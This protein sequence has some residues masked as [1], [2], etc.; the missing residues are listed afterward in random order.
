MLQLYS[1]KKQLKDIK[2]ISTIL[3]LRRKYPNRELLYLIELPICKS[4][5]CKVKFTGHWLRY[6]TKPNV[7]T[8]FTESSQ[9]IKFAFIFFAANL[10]WSLLFSNSDHR[11][12]LSPVYQ[13][14]HLITQHK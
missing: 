6:S 13:L 5:T 14:L 10:T 9:A 8:P 1:E 11:K 4:T 12:V 7:S 2:I 3:H